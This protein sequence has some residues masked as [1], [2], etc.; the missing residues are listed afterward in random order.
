MVD[1]SRKSTARGSERRKRLSLLSKSA[2]PPPCTINK[3]AT[4]IATATTT[5]SNCSTD[6]TTSLNLVSTAASSDISDA[7]VAKSSENASRD[8]GAPLTKES[9]TLAKGETS[10]QQSLSVVANK[11]S[12][13]AAP[14]SNLAPFKSSS[15]PEEKTNHLPV[16]SSLNRKRE[17]SPSPTV[18]LNSKR[19]SVCGEGSSSR[20]NT[21]SQMLTARAQGKAPSPIPSGALTVGGGRSGKM[22]GPVVMSSASRVLT[23]ETLRQEGQENGKLRVLIV[24][25]VRKQGKG[26]S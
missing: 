10:K 4:T 12:K 8:H 18:H 14:N 21:P 5:T 25:E 15:L 16:Q 13:T 11:D 26:E 19:P 3:N 22:E 17:R 6:A 20:L 7:R 9:S 2:T 1:M 23:E 24:K